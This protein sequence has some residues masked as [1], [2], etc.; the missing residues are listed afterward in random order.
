MET[1]RTRANDLLTSLMP[2]FGADD[3]E[4]AAGVGLTIQSGPFS[5]PMTVPAGTTVGEI[6]RRFGVSLHIAA[7]SVAQMDGDLVENETPV[8]AGTILTFYPRAGEKGTR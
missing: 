1:T 7:G 8:R 6:R 2:L 3:P 5:Q 4:P